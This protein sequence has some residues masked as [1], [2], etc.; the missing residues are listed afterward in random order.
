MTLD[1]DGLPL[2]FLLDKL[3]RNCIVYM[4]SKQLA[5]C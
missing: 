2:S 3:I 1:G 4:Y 5:T